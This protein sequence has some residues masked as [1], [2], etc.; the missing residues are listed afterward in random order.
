MSSPRVTRTIR[1]ALGAALLLG[2]AGCPLQTPTFDVVPPGLAISV[3]QGAPL[4]GETITLAALFAQGGVGV[5]LSKTTWATSDQAIVSMVASD[6]SNAGSAVGSTVMAKAVKPGLATITAAAGNL[7]G[8]VVITVLTS[9][10]DVNIIKGP[11]SLTLGAEADYAATVT[12]AT[13]RKV[14]ATV[15]W[16]ASGAVE[17]ATSG[18]NTGSTMRIRATAVGPGA[19]TAQAGGRSAQVAVKVSATKGQLV[20]TR[21][22]GTPVPS[23]LAAG[24]PLSVEASYEVTNEPATDAQWTSTG[25]C[26]LLGTSG[27]TLSVQEMGSGACTLT[28][29][30]KGMS[31]TVTFQIVS[32]TG[33]A[34][35]GDT[36]ALVLGASRTFTAVGLAGT[37]ETGAIAVNWSTDGLVLGLQ[38]AATQAKV[39]AIGVGSTPL[40]ATLAGNITT[41][42]E[43]TVAPTAIRLTAPGTRVIS[44]AG[45]TVTATALG[46]N[47]APGPFASAADLTLTGATGFGSVGAAARQNNGTVTFALNNAMADSPEVKVSL[48][49]VTSNA[50]SFTVA[51]LASVVVM[52]PQG[53]VRVGSTVDFTAVP[54]DAGGTPINGDLQATWADATG[55]YYFPAANGTLKVTATA[56]NLGTAAIVATVGGFAS[57]PFASPAQPSSISLSA[58]SP[59]SVAV[60]GKAMAMVTI[61]D[62]NAAAVRSVPISQVS[63]SADDGTKVSFDAGAVMGFGFVFTATGVAATTPQGVNVTATWT[64]GKFPVMSTTVPL[65]VTP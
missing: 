57:A 20:I 25:A 46:P 4:V 32:I 64:D 52:G 28:A 34:I 7:H 37:L 5:D 55:V 16:V 13:G 43:L 48:G 29:T 24:E 15:T 26:K 51:T 59:P 12:D 38:P 33:L 44:G 56:V 1:T 39:T 6:G 49:G 17:L 61:L 11:T 45:T 54:L 60:G 41:M 35:R 23:A 22:D 65:V 27:A 31:A 53:P 3:S 9:I 63:L 36:S 40:A 14:N 21:A 19:V 42:V 8:V 2:L 58:F 10:G 50:L 47:A 30:A 18:A 62:A